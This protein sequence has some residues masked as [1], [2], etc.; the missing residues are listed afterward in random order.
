LSG[1]AVT[2]AAWTPSRARETA[3]FASP[4]PNVASRVRDDASRTPSG[5]ASRSMISPK[6]TTRVAGVLVTFVAFSAHSWPTRPGAS[7]EGRPPRWAGGRAFPARDRV[8]VAGDPSRSR[9]M[10]CGT[11]CVDGVH[12][13]GSRDLSIT[14]SGRRKVDRSDDVFATRPRSTGAEGRRERALAS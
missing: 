2:N 14:P 6:V 7:W 11:W 13:R 9:P 8:A 10:S 1:T 4:P 3:T 12:R 5:D